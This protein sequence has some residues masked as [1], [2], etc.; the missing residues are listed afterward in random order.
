MLMNVNVIFL[1]AEPFPEYAIVIIVLGS[2]LL[3]VLVITVFVY[4]SVIIHRHCNRL[5]CQFC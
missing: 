2:L 5:I 3:V 4:R 1:C